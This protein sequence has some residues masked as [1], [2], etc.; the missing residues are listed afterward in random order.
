MYDFLCI[1]QT[2]SFCKYRVGGRQIF[3]EPPT[4]EAAPKV[5]A[6]RTGVIAFWGVHGLSYLY[7]IHSTWRAPGRV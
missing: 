4:S 5:D 6:S 3:P 2:G 1:P 7:L